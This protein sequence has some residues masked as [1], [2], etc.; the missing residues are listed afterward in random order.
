VRE[1]VVDVDV[2]AVRDV[3]VLVVR[4]VADVEDEHVVSVGP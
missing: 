4:L 1:F 3:P 2:D